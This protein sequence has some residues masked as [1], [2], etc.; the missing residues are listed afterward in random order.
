VSVRRIIAARCGYG[1]C[2]GITAREC[3]GGDETTFA[4]LECVATNDNGGMS[5]QK[6]AMVL[7]R[8]SRS[9]LPASIGC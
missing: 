4:D 9:A 7:S 6:A 2:A 3:N 8:R 1:V 5:T